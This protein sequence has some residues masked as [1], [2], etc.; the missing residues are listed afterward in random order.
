M[1]YYGDNEI[2]SG[3]PDLNEKKNS[4]GVMAVHVNKFD[5]VAVSEKLEKRV[6]NNQQLWRGVL[7]QIQGLQ[8]NDFVVCLNNGAVL[9]QFVQEFCFKVRCGCHVDNL[10]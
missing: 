6:V 10:R 7:N 9:S 2:V 3:M 4:L 5:H 8:I 1:K